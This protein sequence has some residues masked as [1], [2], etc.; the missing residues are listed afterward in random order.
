M[1]VLST[2][3]AWLGEGASDYVSYNMRLGTTECNHHNFS[4]MIFLET[5]PV[6]EEYPEEQ[7]CFHF[8]FL[9]CL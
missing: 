1:V 6:D 5:C 9:D 8:R 7:E 4:W 2:P 3:A